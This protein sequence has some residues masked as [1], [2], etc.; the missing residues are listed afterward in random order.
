MQ[1]RYVGNMKPLRNMPDAPPFGLLRL[2]PGTESSTFGLLVGPRPSVTAARF[3][4][5]QLS[6]PAA[7]ALY[8]AL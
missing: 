6:F 8:W 1:L 2:V 4:H 3:S 7:P 5:N